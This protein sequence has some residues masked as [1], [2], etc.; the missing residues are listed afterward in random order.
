M[1]RCVVSRCVAVCCVWLWCVTLL[2]LGHAALV[3][4]PSDGGGCC[5]WVRSAV[6][7]GVVCCG[8]VWPPVWWGVLRCCVALLMV[9]RVLVVCGPPN[10][11]AVLHYVV[12]CCVALRCGELCCVVLCCVVCGRLRPPSWGGVLRWCVASL[13]VGRAAFGCFVLRC[14]ALCVVVVCGTPSLWGVLWWCV[15]PLMVGL[16]CVVFWC[17]VLRCGVLCCV[18]LCM[19]V[20]C[21]PPHGGACCVGV[22]P[23]SWSGVLHWGAVCCGVWRCVLW[24]FVAPRMVGRAMPACVGRLFLVVVLLVLGR[25][26]RIGLPSVQ[27]ATPCCCFAG[28]VALPLVL[29]CSAF[30]CVR[31][32]CPDAGRCPFLPPPRRIVPGGCRCRAAVLPFP[33]FLRFPFRR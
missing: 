29:P 22:L 15:A 4:G 23:P 2:T 3:C 8:D 5:V 27:C 28:V 26:G 10:G 25:E 9:G 7:C 24:L 16:C 1:L 33:P 18:V 11:G 13:M 12:L 21:G 30:L 17:V 32:C 6:L 31:G 19:V 20:V 14:V